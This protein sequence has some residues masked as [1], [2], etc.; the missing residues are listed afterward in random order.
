LTKTLK[1]NQK[2]DLVE[3]LFQEVGT[4]FTTS[5]QNCSKITGVGCMDYTGNFN[6]LE[7]PF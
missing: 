7:V 5:M 3:I 4:P 1:K 2:L 6:R